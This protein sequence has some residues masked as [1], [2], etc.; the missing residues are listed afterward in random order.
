VHQDVENNQFFRKLVRAIIVRKSGDYQWQ[1]NGSMK[2]LYQQIGGYL[3]C[4]VSAMGIKGESVLNMNRL[5]QVNRTIH[6]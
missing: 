6:W 4:W 1:I 2:G 5:L 3:A